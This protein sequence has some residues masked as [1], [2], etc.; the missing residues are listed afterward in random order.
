MKYKLDRKTLEVIYKSYIRPVLEYADIVWDDIPNMWVSE[1][2]KIQLN[3]LRIITGL[4]RGT[5]HQVIYSES[6]FSPL[7]TR[8]NNHRL[9][10]FYQIVNE[11]APPNLLSIAPK[12]TD[13]HIHGLRPRPEFIIP[14]SRTESFSNSF[15]PKTTA[16]WNNLSTIIRQSENLATFKSKL[17]SPIRPPVHYYTCISRKADILLCRIRNFASGLNSDLYNNHVNDSPVCACGIIET[18]SH[19][20]L[21]CPIFNNQRTIMLNSIIQHIPVDL[22]DINLLLYGSNQLPLTVNTSIIKN[23]QTFISSTKRFE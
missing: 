19:Y 18:A 16:E 11:T 7:C 22:I 3:A 8:R 13:Q 14:R 4:P 5:S 1:L 2:E 6:G 17:P 15:I 12:R 9:S 20:F 23:V 21:F 10:M